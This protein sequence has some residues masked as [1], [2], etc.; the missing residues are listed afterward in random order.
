[1]NKKETRRAEARSSYY[2][3]S[4]HGERSR[5][6]GKIKYITRKELVSDT[7]TTSIV[8]E[9]PFQTGVYCDVYFRSSESNPVCNG[10][11]KTDLEYHIL[12]HEGCVFNIK[13]SK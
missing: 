8:L 6:Q 10:K 12:E 11:T 9:F 4:E 13:P 2:L 3:F 5:F 7:A 1:M